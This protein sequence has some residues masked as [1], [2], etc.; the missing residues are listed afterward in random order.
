MFST[1]IFLLLGFLCTSNVYARHF[2]RDYFDNLKNDLK[3]H[4]VREVGNPS[5]DDGM[6]K[7]TWTDKIKLPILADNDKWIQAGANKLFYEPFE[8]KVEPRDIKRSDENAI[9]AKRL[10]DMEVDNW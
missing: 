10:I 4:D 8:Y 5:F 3:D 1:N 2:N 7:R 9:I 6:D